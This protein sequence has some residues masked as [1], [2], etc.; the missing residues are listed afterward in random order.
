MSYQTSSYRGIYS[1]LLVG[2]LASGSGA[3]VTGKITDRLGKLEGEAPKIEQRVSGAEQKVSGLEQTVNT[4]RAKP[5]AEA[6][7]MLLK[8]KGYDVEFGRLLAIILPQYTD[9]AS[10]QAA[11]KA[12]AITLVPTHD[13]DKYV[14]VVMADKNG[15]GIPDAGDRTLPDKSADGKLVTGFSVNGSDIPPAVKYLLL[16]GTKVPQ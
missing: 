10:R 15:D 12:D 9:T 2:A 4:I 8:G 5:D 3:C 1:I 13:R 7:V 14:A 6:P 11:E 16:H